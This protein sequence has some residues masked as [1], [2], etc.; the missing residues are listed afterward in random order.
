MCNF[1]CAVLQGIWVSRPASFNP[2]ISFLN[3]FIMTFIFLF[4][5]NM[6]TARCGQAGV[7]GT[8]CISTT[9]TTNSSSSSRSLQNALLYLADCL[10]P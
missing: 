10:Q 9:S 2:L 7:V 3:E 4:L 8:A 5:V 1:V 6:M